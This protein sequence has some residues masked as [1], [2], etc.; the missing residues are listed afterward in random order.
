MRK[1][2]EVSKQVEVPEQGAVKKRVR[3]AKKRAKRV[4]FNPVDEIFVIPARQE[5]SL[6]EVKE[7]A[8]EIEGGR[9]NETKA[10]ERIVRGDDMEGI[11]VRVKRRR[12]GRESLNDLESEQGLEKDKVKQSEKGGREVKE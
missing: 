3:P 4:T 12:R 8:S 9:K 5:N 1:N 11:A 6:W 2:R 7:M 10:K